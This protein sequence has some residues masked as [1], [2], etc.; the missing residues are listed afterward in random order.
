MLQTALQLLLGLFA[1]ALVEIEPSQV[2]AR[3]QKLRIEIERLLQFRFGVGDPVSR[4][5]RDIRQSQKHVCG[6]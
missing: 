6:R 5:Q 4:P 1:Q 2:E 3:P